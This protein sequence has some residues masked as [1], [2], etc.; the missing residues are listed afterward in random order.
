MDTHFNSHRHLQVLKTF[1]AAP[2][3]LN[4]GDKKSV[5][6]GAMNEKG[7]ITR[8]NVQQHINAIIKVVTWQLQIKQLFFLR[9]RKRRSWRL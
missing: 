6:D 4:P 2:E 5:R 3:K 8:R 9:K 1:K 7:C